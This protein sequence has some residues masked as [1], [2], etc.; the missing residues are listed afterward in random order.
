MDR[1]TN[2]KTIQKVQRLTVIGVRG[3]IRSTPQAAHKWHIIQGGPQTEAIRTWTYQYLE[4]NEKWGMQPN[5][6]SLHR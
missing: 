2:R 3:A 5:P 1:E 4:G 6:K